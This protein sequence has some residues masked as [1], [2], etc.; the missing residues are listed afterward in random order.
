[1][2][3]CVTRKAHD[4]RYFYYAC[5][6]RREGRG[7]CPNRRS[8]RAEVLEAAV[9]RA[10]CGLLANRERVRE[11]FDARLRRER[12][13]TRGDPDAAEGALLRSLT[14]VDRTRSRYQEMT[15]K[16]LM[17]FDEL[18]ARLEELEGS[19]E[20][21]LQELEEIQR[22]R[23]S[24]QRLVRDGEA[25]LESYAGPR[26]EFLEDLAAEERHRVYRMLELKVL[27][28]AGG[29]PTVDGIVGSAVLRAL[30]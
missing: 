4:K 8:Y 23:K 10:V 1:M 17:T 30:K 16:G 24:A 20:A 5:A 6:K 22:R 13:G 11:G 15:A 27:V 12:S 2:R 9:R 26:P 29:S 18:R 14:K 28:S 19:R 21:V 3:T 7:V 25:L